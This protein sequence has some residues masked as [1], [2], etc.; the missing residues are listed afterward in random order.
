MEQQ[1]IYIYS[2]IS[3]NGWSTVLCAKLCLVASS[4]TILSWLSMRQILGCNGQRLD[5]YK[6]V[7]QEQNR[8]I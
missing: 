6:I 5:H 1:K 8:C 4:A 2:K 7:E 3:I